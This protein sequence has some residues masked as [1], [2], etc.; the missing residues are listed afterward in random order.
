M[1]GHLVKSEVQLI[2]SN[3]SITAVNVNHRQAICLT[4]PTPTPAARRGRAE[5]GASPRPA[6]DGADAAGVRVCRP[7]RRGATRLAAG[8]CRP[9][10]TQMG[11]EAR[12]SQLTVDS[13][14][15]IETLPTLAYSL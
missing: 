7:S 4:L 13:D 9:H 12:D 5:A 14:L 15:R 1:A 2:I 8:A 10:W 3:E 11:V 6:A